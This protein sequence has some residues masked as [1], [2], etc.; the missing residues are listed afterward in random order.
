MTA[1]GLAVG[2][3]SFRGVA[4]ILIVLVA[5]AI[6]VWRNPEAIIPGRWR[7]TPFYRRS[8]TVEFIL[9]CQLG[10]LVCVG[11]FAAASYGLR[12]IAR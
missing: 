7:A 12:L 8:V 4:V 5:G 2:V 1:L 3:S 6:Q 11:A 9:T 10:V